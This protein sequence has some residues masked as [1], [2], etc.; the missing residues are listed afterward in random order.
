MHQIFFVACAIDYSKN[1]DF[2][3]VEQFPLFTIEDDL[4]TSVISD[5][6]RERLNHL[7]EALSHGS[8][9]HGG[10]ALGLDR[11]VAILVG[12]NSLRDVIAFPKAAD[13]RDL[14]LKSPAIASP[15]E[16]LEYNLIAKP[17]EL[18]S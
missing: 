9:P 16:L 4:G 15:D 12:A 11:L 14:M 5:R 18:K 3:W 8:P 17:K 13:G 6:V 2:L 1:D 7:V 10:I